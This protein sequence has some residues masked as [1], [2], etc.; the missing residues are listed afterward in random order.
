MGSMQRNE[1]ILKKALFADTKSG[2][3]HLD[4]YEKLRDKY[5]DLIDKYNITVRDA[6]SISSLNDYLNEEIDIGDDSLEVLVSNG[7]LSYFDSSIA[8]ISYIM[9]DIGL[10][11]IIEPV[12]WEDMKTYNGIKLI[13]SK[14]NKEK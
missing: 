14:A 2:R 6:R 8:K 4:E 1:F 5:S 3:R 12:K 13:I 9:Y 11:M 7:G 10:E